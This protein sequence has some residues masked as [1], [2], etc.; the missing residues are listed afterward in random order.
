[1]VLWG[2][3]LATTSEF[4]APFEPIVHPVDSPID[5]A[6]AT[7]PGVQRLV[8][9]DIIQLQ[10]VLNAADEVV[11]QLH[12]DTLIAHAQLEASI[13]AL[14]NRVCAARGLAQLGHFY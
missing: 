3:D 13:G 10:Q 5:P 9:V 7:N 14:A 2:F 11:Q 4:V 12:V 8:L 1:M 6:P